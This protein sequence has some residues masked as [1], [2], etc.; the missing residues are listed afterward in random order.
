MNTTVDTDTQVIVVGAGP[1]GLMLA[2][3]LRLGGAEVIVLERLPAPTT[4][5]RA[6][7][8]HARTMEIFDQR[9]LCADLGSPP[10]ETMGHF[11][12]IPLDLGHLPT[13]YPGQ[14]K[15]AQAD[16]E[17]LLARWAV[18]LGAE[19]RRRHD[20]VALSIADD[21][22]RVRAATP[23]GPVSLTARYLVGCDGQDSAVR[24]LSG[25]AFPGRGPT[26]ELL[27]A[28]VSGI[29]VPNRRFQR[30]PLGLA[31]AARR[32]DG[33]TRVM[34]GEYT[35]P[36]GPRTTAAT[37]GEFRAV[38]QRVT[39]EDISGGIP[40]WVNAFDNTSKLAARYR[41]GRLLLAGDAAHA[42]MPSGGQAINLGIQDAANLGWKLAA[43]VTGHA[44][45]EL[46]DTYHDERHET[47]RRVLGNIEAQAL[48]LLGA[49]D[50]EPARTV[51]RELVGH[52]VVRDQLAG[53]ISGLDVRYEPDGHPLTGARMPHVELVAADSTTTSSSALL[54][55]GRGAVL[56]LSADP[57]RRDWLRGALA[58]WA[59]R[60]AVVSAVPT[61][62]ADPVHGLDTVVLRPD[63]YVAWVSSAAADPRPAICRW[64]G[65]AT[66]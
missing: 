53:T 35:E 50:L 10:S 30:L 42:Q 56:D 21:H 33:V 37:F 16:V 1:V 44:P 45:D 18:G 9:G 11:G 8:L 57:A 61:D 52:A 47:G 26:R 2:S 48:L 27:R 65:R 40:V 41:R 38:W 28:D 6:S 55:G 15:V 17:R 31:I 13:R 63:G 49:A 32:P 58:G 66:G 36:A 4:E 14:W 25:V 64:F 60:V 5:S 12:G 59:R 24:A 62:A 3:E 7:T 20:V 54:R 34:V 43:V 39:G 19:V 51:L 29:D 23:A 22:V 46:L